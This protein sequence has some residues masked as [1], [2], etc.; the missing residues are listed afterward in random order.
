VNN[1]TSTIVK[2]AVA[3]L[4]VGFALTFFDITP[5]SLLE[6][7]GGTVKA[8]FELVLRFI[9]WAAEYILIGAVVVVPIWLAMWAWRKFRSK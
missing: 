7:L 6:N 4:I 5:Q 8:I 9:R 2:I 1:V 3:S